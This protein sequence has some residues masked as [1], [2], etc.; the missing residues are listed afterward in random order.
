M[1]IYLK[2]FN[3]TIGDLQANAE[4][5]IKTIK[6][7]KDNGA[8]IVV[9]PEL[10]VCG[11]PP[12]DF[13]L[14]P[15]FLESIHKQ[16]NRIVKASKNIATIIGVVRKNPSERGKPL[17]NSAAIIRDATL[18]GYQDKTLLPTYDVFDERRYFE[19]GM[20]SK[21][22]D[23]YG[24]R[25][26]VTVCEDIWQN[27]NENFPSIYHH[28]PIRD[29]K[30]RRLNLLINISSSPFSVKK[31]H[32][33][34]EICSQAAKNLHCPVV[35]CNQIGGN[36]SIIFDGHSLHVDEKGKLKR[37]AKGFEED[38]LLI[39][40]FQML[41][42]CPYTYHPIENLYKALVLGTKDYFRKQGFKKACLG[43][44]GG[45]DSAV[46]ACIASEA[47][48]KENVIGVFMPSRYSSEASSTDAKQLAQNL[49]I[50]CNT[51][52]IEETFQSYLKLL[53]PSFEGKASDVT[54][55]N[56]QSRIR[57]MILMALSNKLK[58]IVLNTG[59]KSE[60]AIGYATLYGDMCGGLGIISDVSKRQVYALAKWINKT[61]EIIPEN[62]LTK[63]P[64]A[65][66]RPNQKDSDS[67]PPYE[68]LDTV[69]QEYVEEHLP[70]QSIAEKHRYPLPLVI[71]LV[72]KIHQNE[73]KRR[74]SPPGLRVTEKAFSIGRNFPIVHRWN[75]SDSLS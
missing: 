24:K 53:E 10:S 43:I 65:E 62:I 51:I 21:I 26:A 75:P 32:Q 46:V 13:L 27:A 52:P 60:M 19:P 31:L 29:L 35:L 42:D 49:S 8:R 73:Y 67:L 15:D 33:R 23:L 38:N 7:A 69:L 61:D 50:S 70:P 5:I 37:L 20:E 12:R 58:Y 63:A 4:S 57:G 68:I 56:L 64:S 39:S 40:P 3:P 28:N 16:L 48:G 66:L 1:H 44:S 11:Y 17:F 45:I 47:L 14:L 18:L 59:N 72:K 30:N 22:W 6:D 71:E 55:E 25:I 9:F 36:D 41:P 2:Q 74:Q 54:E 34:L